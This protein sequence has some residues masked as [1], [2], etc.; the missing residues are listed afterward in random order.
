MRSTLL[1][2]GVLPPLAFVT[3]C[4]SGAPSGPQQEA[5]VL[6]GLVADTPDKT[7]SPRAAR[8]LF[9]AGAVPGKDELRKYQN[10][11]FEPAG[12]ASIEGT[13]GTIPV[14]VFDGDGNELG[15]VEWTFVKEG[16]TWKIRSAPLP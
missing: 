8:D 4:G 10:Y 12:K 11:T 16:E 2:L 9:A 7:S 14:K 15:Q 3:G 13:T 5:E 6:A 1:C